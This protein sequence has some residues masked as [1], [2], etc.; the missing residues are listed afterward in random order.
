MSSRSWAAASSCSNA[1]KAR[2]WM[3]RRWGMSIPFS[4][5]PKEI[6][7][8]VSAMDHPRADE[9]APPP[10]VAQ[11]TRGRSGAPG[12]NDCVVRFWSRTIRAGIKRG[13]AAIADVIPASHSAVPAMGGRAAQRESCGRLL[14]FDCGALL[15]ELG[16]DLIRFVLVDAGLHRLRRA[17]NEVLCFLEAESGDLTHDLDH[18]N[19][20]GA[21]FLEHDRELGLLFDCRR[22]ATSAARRGRSCANGCS[23]DGDVELG[24]ECLD[25]LGELEDRHVADRFENLILA[26]RR[27]RHCALSLNKSQVFD[28]PG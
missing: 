25:Q 9:R 22:S 13:P 23:R 5:L 3:S 27:V 15:L 18:L 24:L 20:L 8:I 10:P 21:G 11:K 1:S 4:S 2:V 14:D 17:I 26:Q 7:F 6:C 19:L 16:L 28:V 12:N